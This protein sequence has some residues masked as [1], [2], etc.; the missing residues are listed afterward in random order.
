LLGGI[1]TIVVGV[2]HFK[3]DVS[4]WT[5]QREGALEVEEY[6]PEF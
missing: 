6:T 2:D 4:S 3:S 5:V 1:I